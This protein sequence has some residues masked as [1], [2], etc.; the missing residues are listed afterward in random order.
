MSMSISSSPN[1][2]PPVRPPSVLSLNG[3][4]MPSPS[5]S[6]PQTPRLSR[7]P[8]SSLSLRSPTPSLRRPATPSQYGPMSGSGSAVSPSMSYTG[9]IKVSVRVKPN[10][11]SQQPESHTAAAVAASSWIVDPANSCISTKEVGDFNFDHVFDGAGLPNS[12]IYQNSVEPL[13][14]QVMQGFHGTVFAYG[15]TGSGKTFSMQGTRND[16]GIIPLAAESIFNHIDNDP[17]RSYKVTLGYLEIYNEH[18]NDLLTPGDKT[19]PGEETIKLR[20]DV[21][22]GVRAMGLKEVDVRSSQELLDY[23]AQGDSIRRTEGTDFN[24]RSSRS[25]AVVQISIESIPNSDSTG[26]RSHQSQHQQLQR[27][28]STLYLCDLAGSERAV[29]QSERRKEGAFINKSLLTLGTVI[30]RLSSNNNAGHIPYR[31]SKLTRLLQPALSGKSLVSVLCT[32][33]TTAYSY[34]ET[35]STLRFAARAKNIV[36][37]AKRNDDADPSAKTVERL[38]QQVAAQKLEIEQLR[39]N[40][41]SGSSSSATSTNGSGLGIGYASSSGSSSGLPSPTL[42]SMAHMSQL[43]AENRILHERVEHLSRLCDDSRLEDILGVTADESDLDGDSNKHLQQIEEYKSYIAHL[44]K[45]LYN[46]EINRSIN[47]R[48]TPSES[49]QSHLSS[50]SHYNDI[51]RDLKEEIEELRESNRDKDRIINALR[52]SNKRKENLAASLSSTAANSLAYS[53]YYGSNTVSPPPIA[54]DRAD[55]AKE[56][57]PSD[58]VPT[59]KL[60]EISLETN[61]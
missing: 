53:R 58:I 60:S 48:E 32:I 9:N 6:R 21:L 52:A 56:N 17:S 20:D 41:S 49:G 34:I 19:N 61:R 50:G 35:L 57:I 54:E 31:D 40:G 11:I 27:L 3:M 4:G 59:S 24:S 26:V 42:P 14:E 36:V 45:Q 13:V 44:E 46:Q 38:L 7:R 25:H 22:R 8:A 18:L 47:G 51:I 43:E 30:A 33:Q 12:H 28:Q 29:S 5:H 2:R 39:A 23:I 16:P 55:T 10:V 1:K 37:S 15:M